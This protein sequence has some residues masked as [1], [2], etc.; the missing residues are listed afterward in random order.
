MCSDHG[1]I[2]DEIF[3]IGVVSKMLMHIFPDFVIAPAAGKTLVNTIPFAVFIR[4]QAP[5]RSA[6]SNPEHAFNEKAAVG[7]FPGIC[8]GMFFQ[9]SI[10]LFPL[11]VSKGYL[12][13]Y[14]YYHSNVNRT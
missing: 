1:A 9:E 3:H 13:T 6:A 7:F 11:V 10:D 12:C 4:Q 2:D 14:P 8:T 5:L